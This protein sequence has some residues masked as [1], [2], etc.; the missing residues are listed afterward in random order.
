M[1]HITQILQRYPF[2]ERENLIP[3]LQ[4]IQAEQGYLTE[5]ALRQVGRYLNLPASKIYSLATFYN[6]FR[7]HP[8]GRYH[9]RLCRG[10]S[11]Q[12]HQSG[13]LEKKIRQ[14]LSIGHGQTSSDG[15]FSFE[16][17]TCMGACGLG[18]I[19]AVNDTYY[20]EVDEEGIEEIIASYQETEA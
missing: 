17:V 20:T 11:C 5:E 12:I 4:E 1:D 13:K 16:V 10:T 2:V 8:P 9:I 19:V 7:F 14:K 18:P 3:I 15:M 6:H